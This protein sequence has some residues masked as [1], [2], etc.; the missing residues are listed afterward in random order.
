MSAQIKQYPFTG[1]DAKSLH[2]L[3]NFAAASSRLAA[4][5]RHSFIINEVTPGL[6]I[7]TDENL[8]AKVLNQLL[9]TIVNNTKHSCIRIAAKEYDDVIFVSVKNSSGFADLTVAPNFVQATLL[10]RKLNGRIAI[11]KNE[12]NTNSILLSFPNFP[13]AA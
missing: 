6:Q 9:N 1:F 8:L 4:V 5:Q 11:N 12:N 2:Q 13:I 3:V 7:V 10:A